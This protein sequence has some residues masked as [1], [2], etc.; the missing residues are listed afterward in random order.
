MKASNRSWSLN[1][2]PTFSAPNGTLTVVAQDGQPFSVRRV[3]TVI[4]PPGEVRGEHAHKQ[5]AQF[6]VVPSGAVEVKLKSVSASH[7]VTLSSSSSG[8]YVPPMVWGSQHFLEEKSV[9]LVAC[10]MEFVESDYIRSWPEFISLC[11]NWDG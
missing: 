2:L 5:C 4:A 10:D 3:F 1:E 6:L 11:R 8:L 9:L 7:T